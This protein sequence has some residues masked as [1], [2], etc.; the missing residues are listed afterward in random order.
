MEFIDAELDQ[1]V[2]DHSEAESEL[3]NELNRETYLKVLQPRM[4]SGHVQGRIL[5]MYSKLIKP[6]CILEIGTYTGYSAICLA[7]GLGERGILHT[8]EKN[9]ELKPIIDQYFKR[10]GFRDKIELHI[11]DA[12]PIIES[13]DATFDLVFIDADKTNY[14]N[15]YEAVLPKMKSGGCIIADNVLWSGKVLDEDELKNDPDTAVLNEFNKAVT[16]DDRVE[17][18]LLPVR[19][20]L[21]LIRKK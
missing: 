1:Y 17:N 4:L 2:H 3:L 18:V 15:Y 16:A 7:E 12:L 11:G 10:A 9:E 19:D 14:L 5:S 13:M 8:I 21:M 6:E 20:G